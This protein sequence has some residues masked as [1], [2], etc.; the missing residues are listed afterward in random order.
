[1]QRQNQSR[2]SPATLALCLLTT[3]LLMTVG[4]TEEEK[5]RVLSRFFDGVPPPGAAAAA[6]AAAA[7]QAAAAEGEGEGKRKPVKKQTYWYHKPARDDCANCH[8]RR[9]G[10]LV[11]TVADGLCQNCHD[12][13]GEDLRYVHGPVAANGCLQCHSPHES[14]QPALLLQAPEALCVGCHPATQLSPDPHQ[15]SDLVPDTSLCTLCHNPHGG[16]NRMFL[17]R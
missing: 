1:M 3:L 9:G 13:P 6:A 14:N 11:K 10:P 4:C 2:R 12:L 17:R 8:E 16:D 5:Y 15:P 7:E